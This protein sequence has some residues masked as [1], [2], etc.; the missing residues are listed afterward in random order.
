MQIAAL[1]R[2]FGGGAWRRELGR[3]LAQTRLCEATHNSEELKSAKQNAGVVDAGTPGADA[4][5]GVE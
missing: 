4:P 5:P 1:R 3:D 2:V